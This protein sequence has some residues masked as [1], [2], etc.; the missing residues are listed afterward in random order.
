MELKDTIELMTSDDYRERFKAEYYQLKIRA[1]NLHSLLAKLDA[2]E[3]NFKPTCPR[4]VLERQLHSM[5]DYL[6]E[7]A[8]RADLEGINLEE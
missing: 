8:F 7:L 4:V 6:S 1:G 2:D 5:L 3:L